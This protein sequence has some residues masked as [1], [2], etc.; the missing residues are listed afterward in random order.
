M[1]SLNLND[2]EIGPD[3]FGKFGNDLRYLIELKMSNTKL[4]NKS[5]ID[6]S[7]AMKEQKF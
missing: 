5:M 4:N 7:M 6:L 2:N 3:F 1:V